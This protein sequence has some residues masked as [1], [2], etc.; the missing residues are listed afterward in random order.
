[1]WTANFFLYRDMSIYLQ[2]TY[3]VIQL[4][5]FSISN[6]GL[7]ITNIVWEWT[8]SLLGSVNRRINR[9]WPL[10][11]MQQKKGSEKIEM[12]IKTVNEFKL[13]SS[14]LVRSLSVLGTEDQYYGQKI[15]AGTDW[16][17]CKGR[18]IS[19]RD[20]RSVLGTEDQ[21]LGQEIGAWDRRSVLGINAQCPGHFMGTYMKFWPPFC[22]PKLDADLYMSVDLPLDKK[23]WKIRTGPQGTRPSQVAGRWAVGRWA[24][25]RRAAGPCRPRACF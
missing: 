13:P 7:K 22:T 4:M 2:F 25:G 19:A 6:Y 23:L 15:S 20:R 18:K 11:N 8:S 9:E 10:S 17:Q 5:T 14:I 21:C 12:I 16:G 1:M 3:L 24:F